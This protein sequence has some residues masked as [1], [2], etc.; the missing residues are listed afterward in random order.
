MWKRRA[1]RLVAHAR[2]D[3]RQDHFEARTFTRLAYEGNGTVH[4]LHERRDHRQTKTC[5]LAQWLAGKERI[6]DLLGGI[7][8]HTRPIVLDNEF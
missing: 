1:R 8:R 5:A 3:L 2:L 6:E 7:A 4:V